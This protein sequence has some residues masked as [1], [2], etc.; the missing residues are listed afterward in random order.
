MTLCAE[1]PIGCGRDKAVGVMTTA[2][3]VCGAC[4]VRGSVAGHRNRG[5]GIRSPFHQNRR[6]NS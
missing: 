3:W 1:P 2:G 5:N 4:D 6:P